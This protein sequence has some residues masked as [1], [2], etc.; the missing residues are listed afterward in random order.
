MI[1]PDMK[2]FIYL[3]NICLYT[4]SKICLYTVNTIEQCKEPLYT[5]FQCKIYRNI[6]FQTAYTKNPT[7][8]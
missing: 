2:S 5:K 6:M 8:G 7:K 1:S 3:Y 4:V